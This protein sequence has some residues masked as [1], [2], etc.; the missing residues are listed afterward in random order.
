MWPVT[1]YLSF[2]LFTNASCSEALSIYYTNCHTGCS[3]QG[4]NKLHFAGCW[5]SSGIIIN[6]VVVTFIRDIS[7]GSFLVRKVMFLGKLVTVRDVLEVESPC[8]SGE[9]E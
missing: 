1:S 8:G 6:L 2:S 7:G 3:C 5:Y 9:V 4:H